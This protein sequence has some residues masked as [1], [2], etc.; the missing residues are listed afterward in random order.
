MFILIHNYFNLEFPFKST[1]CSKTVSICENEQPAMRPDLLSIFFAY[2]CSQTAS[3]SSNRAHCSTGLAV[4]SPG[5]GQDHPA[6]PSFFGQPCT[7]WHSQG[8]G[9]VDQS[10]Q[11][12]I[13]GNVF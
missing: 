10:F 9:Q 8:I 6:G 2:D 4:S 7:Q 5:G 12:S 11:L 1:V 3:C 13:S